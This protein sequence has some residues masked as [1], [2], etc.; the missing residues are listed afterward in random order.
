MEIFV[1][2][3]EDFSFSQVL[4]NYLPLGFV[5]EKEEISIVLLEKSSFCLF[6]FC[7]MF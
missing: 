4:R 5:M 2:C 3:I 7:F 6:V 1:F